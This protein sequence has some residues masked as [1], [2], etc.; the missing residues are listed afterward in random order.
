[1]FWLNKLE[2]SE[3]I[4]LDNISSF[5]SQPSTEN[6]IKALND[7]IVAVLF[8]KY[9][10]VPVGKFKELELEF[11]LEERK[12]PYLLD[13]LE[14]NNLGQHIGCHENKWRIKQSIMLQKIIGEWTS[15][16]Q[17]VAIDPRIIRNST[18]FIWILLFARKTSNSVA[19]DTNLSE[20]IKKDIGH[21][22]E[23]SFATTLYVKDKAFYI[24]PYH[25]VLIQAIVLQRTAKENLEYNYLLPDNEVLMFKRSIKKREEVSLLNVF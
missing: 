14:M 9:K 22:F 10:E 12:I 17:V 8:S 5:N 3:A 18:F 7:L 24:K 11:Q 23:Q 25:K 21:L 15:E 16:G 4:S 13:Y 1:M 6:S 2:Y 19:L 20:S